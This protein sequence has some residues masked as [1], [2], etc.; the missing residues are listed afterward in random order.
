MDA[1]QFDQAVTGL[2]SAAARAIKWHEALAPIARHLDAW[3]VKICGLNRDQD[4]VMYAHEAG[5]APAEAA[6]EYV[7]EW[8]AR[9]P[10]LPYLSSMEPGQWVSCHEVPDMC[11]LT[12]HPFYQE[13]LL[14]FGGRFSSGTK[15]FE[16]GPESAM[17]VI[18][19]SV[20]AQPLNPATLVLCQR[21]GDH[22]R[23]AVR[24]HG[25]SCLL[26]TEAAFGVRLLR[27]L[28]SPVALIDEDGVVIESNAAA[29]RLFEHS[30][31]FMLNGRALQCRRPADQQGLQRALSDLRLNSPVLLG[32]PLPRK[33]KT[34]C[35]IQNTG[36]GF[37][38]GVHL[39]A[40]RPDRTLGAFGRRALALMLIH[41]P[42][43][44]PELDPQVVAAV[45]DLTPAE[46]RVAVGIAAGLSPEEIGQRHGTA[47]TTV[48]WQLKSVF[49]K[50][51]VSRQAE[52]ASRLAGLAASALSFA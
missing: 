36:K 22:L 1:G 35:R 28:R 29:Q 27:H 7:R 30:G 16:D 10:R 3:A 32:S 48:R 52:L 41:D 2:Y 4:T 8:H 44:R 40:V 19:G 15:I 11:S 25:K 18:M 33:E 5:S 14:P 38:Y 46:A 47:L 42:A 12:G 17:F 24:L 39:S 13:Y 43:A 50:T 20:E 26:T 9:D 21:L 37:G 31:A 49:A 51:G 45:Y 34:F 23:N 6:L